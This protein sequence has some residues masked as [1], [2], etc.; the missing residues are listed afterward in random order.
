M[1]TSRSLLKLYT[2]GIWHKCSVALRI[3]ID[4]DVKIYSIIFS[5]PTHTSM[6]LCKHTVFRKCHWLKKNHIN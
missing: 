5:K 1:Y 3:Y 6:H 2:N 4:H